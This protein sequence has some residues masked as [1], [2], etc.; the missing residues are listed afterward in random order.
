MGCSDVWGIEQEHNAVQLLGTLIRHRQLKQYL[1]TGMFLERSERSGVHYCFRRLR[2]TIACREHE[3]QMR[4]LAALCLHP[5]GYYE[6]T[7]SGAMCP[8]E[9]VIGHLMLMR[10]DE[11]MLWKRSN[12][13]APWQPQAGL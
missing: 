3:G 1:L 7:W 6:G 4:I 5:I 13:I 11:H 12:Q 8:T 10:G 2:P 9:D